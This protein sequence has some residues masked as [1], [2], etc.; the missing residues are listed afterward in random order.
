ML[1]SGIV[2]GQL[3][4]FAKGSRKAFQAV[5]PCFKGNLGDG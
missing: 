3:R 5:K 1:T 2:S 4:R